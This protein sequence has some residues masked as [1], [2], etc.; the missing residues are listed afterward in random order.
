MP[1]SV[2]A[3][4]DG[5]KDF[6]FLLYSPRSSLNVDCCNDCDKDEEPLLQCCSRRRAGLAVLLKIRT[7]IMVGKIKRQSVQ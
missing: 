1:G 6:C 3:G 7:A 2:L 5:E 4:G